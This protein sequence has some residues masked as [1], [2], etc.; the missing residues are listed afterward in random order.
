MRNKFIDS[1]K[2]ASRLEKTT[3][4]SLFKCLDGC[5]EN[6]LCH[7]ANYR[8]GKCLIY[9]KTAFFELKTSNM[10]STA[11]RFYHR[12]MFAKKKL[13]G[14]R[15]T[16]WFQNFTN[17]SSSKTCWKRCMKS[18][19][20]VASSFHKPKSECFLFDQ[21]NLT[22]ESGV[23]D[24]EFK[25]T[26]FANI[27]AT[28]TYPK[29]RLRSNTHRFLNTISEFFC[30]NE[31]LRDRKC[32]GVSYRKPKCYLLRGE[33]YLVEHQDGWVSTV[34]ET[35][36]IENKYSIELEKTQLVG[37]SYL[38]I[39]VDNQTKHSCW[40]ECLEVSGC[41]AV[42]FG[43][44]TCRL[45]AKG[46]FL[47]VRKHNWVSICLENETLQ[48]NYTNRYEHMVLLNPFRVLSKKSELACWEECLVL[49]ECVAV[50][51]SHEGHT[52]KFFKRGKADEHL[53][54]VSKANWVSITFENEILDHEMI[55]LEEKFETC[56]HSSMPIGIY[57]DHYYSDFVAIVRANSDRKRSM[58]SWIKYENAQIFGFY[59]VVN[60]SS[61]FE[62]WNECVK[63]TECSGLSYASYGVCYLIGPGK[64]R[65]IRYFNWS[66][67]IYNDP[68]QDRISRNV[69]FSVIR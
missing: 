25:T 5:E 23:N 55:M 51:F 62:C 33:D 22:L 12:K 21:E 37:E 46:S 64:Y 61:E 30:W 10:S 14:Y 67:I 56:Q 65:L 57:R 49:R 48:T 39:I 66:S 18:M 59:L 42:T 7:Y 6:P 8:Q 2:K 17:I 16:N 60:V 58:T 35:Q 44:S 63:K 19:E 31:C 27:I 29:T 3:T 34:Y 68:N 15:L 24:Q 69:K 53:K 50:S 38:R 1:S 45:I 13:K 9:D 41:V 36:R 54:A 11:S 52:C 20:C 32:V 28:K 43:E 4:S 40:H 47:I 26:C